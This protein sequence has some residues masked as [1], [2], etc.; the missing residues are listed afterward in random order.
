MYE[1]NIA[2]IERNVGNTRSRVAFTSGVG[3]P[4][5]VVI[6]LQH[7]LYF[8]SIVL[9]GMIISHTFVIIVIDLVLICNFTE[10]NLK[11]F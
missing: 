3:F 1:T 10:L 2:T 9:F 6:I 8:G 11:Q 4:I 5:K 7:D